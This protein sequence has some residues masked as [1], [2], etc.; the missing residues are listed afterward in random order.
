MESSKKNL[1][2]LSSGWTYKKKVIVLVLL[3]SLLRLVTASIVDLGNDESYYWLY[4]QELKWNYFDHPPLVAI[5][6]RIFTGNL[7]LQDHELFLRLGSISGCAIST[8]FMYKCVST[9]YDERSGWFAAVL[10]NASFYAGITSGLFIMP[11]TPQMVFWTWSLWMLAKIHTDDSRWVNWIVLGIVSGLCIM[12][13][14][15]GIFIWSGIVAYS[16]FVKRQWL[17]NPRIYLSAAI[18]LLIASPILIWNIENNFVTYH[19]HVKRVLPSAFT[20]SWA[21]FLREFLGQVIINNIFNVSIIFIAVVAF[22]FKRLK[23]R[24][25]LALYNFIGLPLCFSVLLISLYRH[26]FPHWSGPAYITLI[27]VAAV[28]L[29]EKNKIKF[30]PVLKY[31]LGLY[32]LFV[33]VCTAEIKCYPGNFGNKTKH[34]MGKGDITLDMNGWSDAGKRFGEIYKNE[35]LKGNA[36][37]SSPVVCYNWWGS[38]IEYYFCRPL[39]IPMIGL[40]TLDDLHQYAWLNKERSAQVNFNTAYCIVPT[41]ENYNVYEQYR[42]YYSSVESIAV[43]EIIRSKTPTH[44]FHVYRLK[45]WKNKMPLSE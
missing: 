26:T 34:D 35:I 16:F 11:D 3:L 15:H 2:A 4:S 44:N 20:L 36:V 33:I 22:R 42:D 45:G 13:K 31:S 37:P 6:I 17:V 32:I 43:I 5:W 40:G 25:S 28:Y 29:S 9:L 14:V 12:S 19:F 39:R 10:Y 23:H 8:W 1:Q 24:N 38:H 21:N 18:A 30:P 27:P 7:L 41:D